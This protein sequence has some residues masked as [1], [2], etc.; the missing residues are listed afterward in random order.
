[1]NGGIHKLS[2]FTLVVPIG[3]AGSSGGLITD[4]CFTIVGSTQLSLPEFKAFGIRS[5]LVGD[6]GNGSGKE[7]AV[8]NC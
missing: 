8:I 6:S 5:Q 7:Y 4:T 1:M 3:Y 2:Q